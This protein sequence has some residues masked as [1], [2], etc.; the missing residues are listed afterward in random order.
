MSKCCWPHCRLPSAV[1]YSLRDTRG[2]ILCEKHGD[3]VQDEDE[4]VM[5]RSRR[6]IGMPLPG[7][8][9]GGM[10][11][12]EESNARCSFPGCGRP[13]SLVRYREDGQKAPVCD[14][15]EKE[16]D[17]E[18]DGVWQRFLPCCKLGNAPLFESNGKTLMEVFAEEEPTE[19]DKERLGSLMERLASDEFDVP[20][21]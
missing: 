9:P 15:H 11:T 16:E 3:L 2:F 13:V 1:T 12:R 20:E 21:G 8:Y 6:K 17:Y 10:P 14:E 5:R 18:W 4:S 19:E 7:T